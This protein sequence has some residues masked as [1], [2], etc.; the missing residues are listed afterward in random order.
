MFCLLGG[1]IKSAEQLR[2]K[3]L[4][5]RATRD[6]TINDFYPISVEKEDLLKRDKSIEDQMVFLVFFQD[7]PHLRNRVTRVCNSFMGSLFEINQG[8]IDQQ[9]ET[10]IAR[11]NEVK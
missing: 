5:M 8:S 1:T 2:F 6:K 4:M 7:G 9:L 3:T 11:K 10:S